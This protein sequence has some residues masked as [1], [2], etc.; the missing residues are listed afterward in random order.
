MSRIH[1]AIRY[2]RPT[3]EE[4]ANIWRKLF[5]KLAQDQRH[6]ATARARAPEATKAVAGAKPTIIIESSARDVVLSKKQYPISFQLNGRDI[7]N[8]ECRDPFR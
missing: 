1:L 3:D 8:R 5:D 4:R 2:E 7:R 6:E